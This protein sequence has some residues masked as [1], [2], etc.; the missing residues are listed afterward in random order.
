MTSARGISYQKLLDSDTQE[1]PRVLRLDSPL[2]SGSNTVPIER[3]TSREFFELEVEK[4]WRRAWQMACREEDIPEVGDHLVYDIAGMSF[5]LVRS[6]PSE[7]KCF[8]NA[9]LHRGRLLREQRGRSSKLRCPFHG[10]CWSLDGELQQI[11]ADWDFEHIDKEENRLPEARVGT[12]GGF[13]FI[14]PDADCEPLAD[15]LGDFPT[16]F[17]RWP[18][19]DRYKAVHVAKILRCNWKI[20]Q[21]AFMEALHVVATHPQLM[22][23]IGDCNSQYDVFE[24][25]SRTITPNGTPSPHLASRPS[26]QDMADNVLDNDFGA[27]SPAIVAEGSTA[28]ATMAARRR[29]VMRPGL[30]DA[31]DDLSDAEMMDSM[32]YTI[33]PNFHPWGSYNRIV[34]R[35]RPHGTNHRESIME[36]IYLEPVPK[37]GR[38]PAADIHWLGPDDDWVDAPELGML[39]RVFNQDSFNLPKVQLGVETTQRSHIQLSS[40]NES[41][42]R[43]FHELLGRW[44]ERP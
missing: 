16:H 13:V 32:Y 1:V 2:E 20:A 7:I 30:G 38:P 17:E 8:W 36:V 21:E 19:E 42:L 11:P 44:V 26:E 34:Y 12:W 37:E 25:F 40:Y 33:F 27:P 41:K 4:V 22:C 9:C 6:G 18:L 24:N 29:D 31:A 28:R 39:A 14:N 10:W 43:H 3:Y 35:F 23:S 15:F 5:L